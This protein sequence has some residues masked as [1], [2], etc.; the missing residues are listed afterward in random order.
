MSP[1]ERTELSAP[2]VTIP[3]IKKG[4]YYYL[5]V[6][7]NG[8]PIQFTLET[9]GSLFA[10]SARAAKA[11]GLRVDSV[12][13]APGVPSPRASIDSLNIGGA[14]LHG[15]IARVDAQF[16]G[17]NEDGLVS[18]PMLADLLWTIDLANSR[19]VLERGSLPAPNGRDVF[20]IAGKDRGRRIDIPLN[21]GGQQEAAVLDTRYADW[22]IVSDSLIPRLALAGPLRNAGTAWGPAQGTFEMRGARLA[23]SVTL[24]RY[25][26]P[27]AAIVFRDRRGAVVGNAFLEQFVI[28]VD[29]KNQRVR[30]QRPAGTVLTVPPQFWETQT[31]AATPQSGERTFGF[32]MGARPGGALFIVQLVPRSP[33]EKLGIRENDRVI[34]FDG[35]P[36]AM[37]NPIIFRS[38]LARGDAVKIVV[39]REGK[40]VEFTIASYVL[41]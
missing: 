1:P 28:T 12:E 22:I 26:V 8:K 2:S 37:M 7:V 33:A 40:N 9:G 35:T 34:S 18:I 13:M 6:K 16:D 3:L 17:M 15:L 19:L 27:R 11:L 5:D 30:F 29:Y 39:E 21:V 14:T 32:R 23:D 10:I 24:G 41:P 38:A 31:V 36:A 20:A 25:A 4:A